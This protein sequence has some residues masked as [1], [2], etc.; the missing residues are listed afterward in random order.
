MISFVVALCVLIGGYWVYGNVVERVFRP[1]VNRPTA[2]VTKADGVDYIPMPTWK[3]FFIQLLNI[4]GLGPVFGAIMGAK[5]G[6]SCYL[7]IVLGCIFGGGVHDYLAGMIS[8]RQDGTNLST[9]IGENLGKRMLHVVTWCL[10]I[11]MLL[12][13]VVFVSGPAGLLDNMTEHTFGIIP[14]IVLILLYYLIATLLPMDKIIGKLY[15]FFAVSMLV[16]AIGILGALVWYHPVLPEITDMHNTHSNGFAVFPMMF[17]SIACGAISGFHATQS[18]MV[19]RCMKSERTGRLVFYG[20][21]V[22]EGIIALIWAAAAQYYYG[23]HGMGV[24]N[25]A[26]VVS[27]LSQ[28][29]LGVFGGIL[30]M[31]GVVVA[32]ITTGDTALR[33]ARLIL[34]EYLHLPQK[35]L[36][37]RLAI[38]VPLILVSVAVLIYSM[39]DAAGFDVIWRYFSWS[40]QLLATITLWSISVY[41]TRHTRHYYITL[42]PALFMTMV[43]T[44]YICVAPEG[45]AMPG[46]LP[47]LLSAGV[48]LL[49]LVWFIWKTLSSRRPL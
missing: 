17:V 1:D 22:T 47:Y 7:W 34:A 21:M 5:F 46:V 30:I 9:I 20:A 32:P 13:V 24:S 37:S 39:R 33:S 11:L 14:W 41:L 8:L 25:A 35:T 44:S 28:E 16:M 45:F 36:P 31:I 10:I 49:L 12:V 23:Q 6:T 42:L 38:S 19:A 40:N 3:L 26:I 2:A 18:P 29:W 48:T 15:P 43:C 27:D 4:A